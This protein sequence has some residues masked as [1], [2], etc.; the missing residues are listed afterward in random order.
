MKERNRSGAS[1]FI[2]S[3]IIVEEECRSSAT[4]IVHGLSSCVGTSASSCISSESERVVSWAYDVFGHTWMGLSGN[5][6]LLIHLHWS[7]FVRLVMIN[8][9]LCLRM[10]FVSP[11][12]Y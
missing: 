5:E 8:L 10:R 1:V 2:F 3:S 6:I 4:S 12:V 7:V 11:L 9:I